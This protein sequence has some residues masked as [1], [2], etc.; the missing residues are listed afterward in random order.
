MLTAAHCIRA[1]APG[2]IVLIGSS[3]RGRYD[4]EANALRL[5]RTVV[6]VE[7]HPMYNEETIE[8]DFMLLQRVIRH[9]QLAGW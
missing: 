4:A 2:S 9:L 3:T 5:S 6:A 1:F 7:P 8:Y